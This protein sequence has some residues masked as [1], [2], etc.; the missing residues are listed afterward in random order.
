MTAIFYHPDTTKTRVSFDT[1]RK[2]A[3]LAA[4]LR[5]IGRE[6]HEPTPATQADIA[7]CH[8]SA[9][10][11][12]IMTGRPDALATSQ[13]FAWDSDTWASVTAQ[14]GAMIAAAYWALRYGRAYA[15][16][17]GFH[18]ARA[19]HGAGFCTFNG[20]AI[21]AAAALDAGARQVVILDLDAHHGGGTYSIVN[22]WEQLL[23]LDVSTA[24]FDQY[25]SAAPHVRRFVAD[26]D[27]YLTTVSDVLHAATQ[28]VQPGD[29]V[30]YNAGMDI[31]GGCKIGGLAG[32]SAD[33]IRARE[34]LVHDWIRA[35]QLRVACCL[36][37][38]Y[39]SETYPN[40]L[41]LAL[42]AHSVDIFCPA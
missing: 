39:M 37:G 13:G 33:I 34:A 7:R 2:G 10:I 20:L 25:T 30:L 42:H 41:L 11:A 22:A 28:R 23:H 35:Q 9:Y 29:L 16:A 38:G 5:A 21:A 19:D 12:A 17:S 1:T 4:H 27:Q 36:A 31:Y 24:S 26:P 15:L 14:T 32:I 40:E 18:H 6:I 3:D 8:S